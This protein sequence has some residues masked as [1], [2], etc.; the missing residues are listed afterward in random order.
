MDSASSPPSFSPGTVDGRGLPGGEVVVADLCIIGGGPAGLSIAAEFAGTGISLVL[1]ESGAEKR[2][3]VVEQLGEGSTGSSRYASL[4]LYRRRMLGGASTIWGGRCVPFDPIDFEAREYVPQSGWPFARSA[5]D[6]YY[7]RATLLAEAGESIFDADVAAPGSPGLFADFSSDRVLTRSLERF[8]LPTN[9]WTR[10]GPSLLRSRNITVIV[11]ASC[12][13]IGVVDGRAETASFETLA[14]NKFSVAAKRYIVA[15]G[16]IETYRLLATPSDAYPVGIGNSHDNLGRYFMSH[17]EGSVATL[18]MTD[19]KASVGWGFVKTRDGVYGRRRLSVPDVVQREKK[20][21]NFIARLHH[22]LPMDPRHDSA[23]LSTMFLAKNFILP[24]YRRKLTMVERMAGESM[25]TGSAFWRHHLGNVVKGS[26]QLASFLGGWIVGR[27]LRKRRIPYVVLPSP[28]G[29][30]PLDFN[31]EQM[32]NRDSRIVLGQEKDRLGVPLPE[33]R[34]A[35]TEQDIA[36]IVGNHLVMRD[37]FASS[38]IA[39]IELDDAGFEEKVRQEALPIGGHHLGVARMSSEPR[40]GVVNADLRLHDV[41]NV[42]VAGGAVLPTSSHANPTLTILALSL[43]L[44]DHL[45]G[46]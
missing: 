43:R 20:L 23:I 10:L 38:G 27:H 4:S 33:I 13:A 17:I 22:P 35:L 9:F 21:L 18:K 37:A 28:A 32:P 36:S 34:W 29:V 16:G 30:Y 41:D 12:T 31:A 7:D 3:K 15:A 6:P 2:D 45:K 8:S 26:P 11:N 5:L 40:T 39:T 14:G 19:R 44:C 1:V 46:L 24:E 42:Y 25:P